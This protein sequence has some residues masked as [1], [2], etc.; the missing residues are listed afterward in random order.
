VLK[1]ARRGPSIVMERVTRREVVV[2]SIFEEV[3]S[4]WDIG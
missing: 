1:A 3:L 4:L 2:E